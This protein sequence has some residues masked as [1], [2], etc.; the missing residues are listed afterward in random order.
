M[1]M[2]K[3]IL[4]TATALS[5]AVLAGGS[6]AAGNKSDKSDHASSSATST[7]AQTAASF[8]KLKGMKVQDKT[9]EDVGKISDAVF[10]TQ[11][12]RVEF[13]ILSSS[14]ALGGG[15]KRIAIPVQA[16]QFQPDHK[17]AMV[18]VDREKLKNAPEARADMSYSRDFAR[19]VDQYYGVS[20][21]FGGSTTGSSSMGQSATSSGMSSGSQSGTTSG[22]STYRGSGS[23]TDMNRGSSG[24]SSGSMGTSR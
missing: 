4:A 23:T 21:S 16:L 7:S 12:G 9:G 19:Q 11:S 10:D 18:N 17:T 22:D 5:V 6:Y 1:I 13:L 14:S 2:S 3:S 24:S 15:H 20:P 8:D